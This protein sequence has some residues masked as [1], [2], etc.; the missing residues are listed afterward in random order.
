MSVWK[1]YDTGVP[2]KL[3][4]LQLNF[5]SVSCDTGEGSEEQHV[6]FYVFVKDVEA[7]LGNLLKFATDHHA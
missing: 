3:I 7:V 5:L 6:F 1:L 2:D 4:L